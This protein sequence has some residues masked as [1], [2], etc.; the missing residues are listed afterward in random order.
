MRR[1]WH[2][3]ILLVAVTLSTSAAAWSCE[4]Q[5]PQWKLESDNKEVKLYSRVRPGSALKEF[6]AVGIIDAPT[7]AVHRVIN[8]YEAY[9]K[10]MPYTA[11]VRI[12]KREEDSIFAYQRLSPGIV[13]DRDYTLRVREKSWTTP[14]GPVFF[15]HWQPAN[16]SGPAERDGVLRVRLCEGSWLLEPHPAMKTKATYTIYTDSGGSLPR[17]VA[18]AA[19]GIGIRKIFTAIRGQVKN[20]KYRQTSAGP[21]K[22]CST[23]GTD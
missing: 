15:S 18:S 1:R 23:E 13:R 5:D 9:P 12:L 6:R 11:E 10:F 2:S 3:T 17:F 22:P 14:A 21:E 20:P 7:R 8:D 16:E 4:D 19:S